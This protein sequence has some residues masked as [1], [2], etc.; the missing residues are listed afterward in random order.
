MAKVLPFI[1]KSGIVFD[2]EVTNLIG[3]AF[4]DACKKLHDA[5]QPAVVYEVIARRIIEAANKGE[6]DSTRLRQAGLAAFGLDD[7]EVKAG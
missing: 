5:G 3:S 6:R 4:D 1:A 7:D 2:D